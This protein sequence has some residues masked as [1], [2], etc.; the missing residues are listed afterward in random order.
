MVAPFVGVAQPVD[1]DLGL[2]QGSLERCYG[3][4]L[5]HARVRAEIG[6]VTVGEDEQVAVAPVVGTVAVHAHAMTVTGMAGDAAATDVKGPE[7]VEGR[8]VLRVGAFKEILTIFELGGQAS[9]FHSRGGVFVG[10][11]RAVEGGA[12]LTASIG[13]LT[14][15]HGDRVV[16][17]AGGDGCG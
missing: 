16:R 2:V 17:L 14:D 5:W 12:Q 1:L 11:L 4:G 10:T 9:L 8:V 15:N 6:V 7:S 3:L 13:L